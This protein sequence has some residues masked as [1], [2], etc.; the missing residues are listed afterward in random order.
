MCRLPVAAA[1]PTVAAVLLIA[2][3]GPR[4]AGDQ[5]TVT[6]ETPAP[7]PG[8]STGPSPSAP[9]TSAPSAGFI[10]RVW[11]VV[12]SDAV[13][14][15]TLYVFMAESTL[16]IDGPGGTPAVG[17]W[18]RDG[19]HLVMVEEGIAYP[20]DILELTADSFRI[21]SHNPGKAVEI[22]LVPAEVTR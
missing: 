8:P 12:A 7:S 6:T 13:A 9:D 15:G 21:L 11:R 20:T 3:C 10:N 1:I 18:R 17:S 16:V 14:P 5:V 19:D 2:G 4:P 22:T